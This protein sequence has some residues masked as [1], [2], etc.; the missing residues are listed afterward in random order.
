M[1]KP[2]AKSENAKNTDWKTPM[3]MP[4]TSAGAYPPNTSAGTSP[5]RNTDSTVPT[6]GHAGDIDPAGKALKRNEVS[7]DAR[8]LATQM[9]KAG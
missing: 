8:K 1:E 2:D 4:G 7:P 5:M 6:P 9:D 3:S